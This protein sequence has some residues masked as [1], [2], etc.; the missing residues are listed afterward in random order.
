MPTASP[1]P[2]A[3]PAPGPGAPGPDSECPGARVVN[4]TTG[5][6][7]KQSSVFDVTGSSFRVTTSLTGDSEFLFFSVD[8]NKENGGYA[9]SIDRESYGTDSSIVNAGPGNF[10]LDILAA[11]TNYTVT[12]EDC[13]GSAGGDGDTGGSGGQPNPVNNPDEVIPDTTSRQPI[14]DTGGPPYL[15]VGAVVLLGTALLV[16]R[17]VLKR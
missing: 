2:T 7:D 13:A 1:V 8:V 10:F 12:V 9:T 14:P 5:S 15:P 3:S 11:N 16:G 17:G 6:G 4:T